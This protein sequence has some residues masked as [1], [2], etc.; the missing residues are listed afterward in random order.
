MPGRD[1]AAERASAVARARR[2]S[3]ASR[4]RCSPITPSHDADAAVPL[5]PERGPR[6][7]GSADRL[8]HVKFSE[9]DGKRVALWGL[10]RETNA[11]RAQLEQRLPD[12]SIS[13]V[14]DDS[15]PLVDARGRDR[16]RRRTR[17]FAR[18][19]DLQAADPGGAG[20]PQAGHDRRRPVDGGAPGPPRDR[21]DRDQ[22]Q[23]HDRDRDRA[24]PQSRSRRPSSPATSAGR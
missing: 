8:G 12:A 10:G 19:L 5:R 21:R 3:R 6:G 22:G 23:E 24:P 13:A 11:F 17:A 4:P 9:L 16:G 20:E 2:S 7:P 14:I 18:R 15:T 1:P